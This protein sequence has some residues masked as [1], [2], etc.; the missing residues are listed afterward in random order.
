M[1]SFC[2]I[3]TCCGSALIWVLDANAA[4]Y[5]GP[6]STHVKVLSLNGK[7]GREIGSIDTCSALLL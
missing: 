7:G 6:V 4:P 1:G 2:S 3:F 5:P